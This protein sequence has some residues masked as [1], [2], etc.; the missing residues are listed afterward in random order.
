MNA[1]TKFASGTTMSARE[2]N[3]HTSRAKQAAERGPV[4]ITDRGKPAY[5]LL[6]EAE[7]RRLTD[8]PK[9]VLEALADPNASP[10]DL[11]LMDFIPKRTVEPMFEFDEE[12]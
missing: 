9:S 3:Q 1:P 6:T 4:F 11:N 10:D 2:F 7:Y 8:R 12:E 5:V